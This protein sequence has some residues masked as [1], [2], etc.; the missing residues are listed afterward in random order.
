MDSSKETQSIKEIT[1]LE[2]S[3]ATECEVNDNGEFLKDLN[4]LEIKD[5]RFQLSA[6]KWFC[7][8][9]MFLLFFQNIAVFGLV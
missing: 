6:R 7:M 1:A 4:N 8:L 9:L 3:K 5:L 2:K